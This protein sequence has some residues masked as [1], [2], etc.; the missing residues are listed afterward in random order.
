LITKAKKQH[1]LAYPPKGTL[2][3]EIVCAQT[4]EVPAPGGR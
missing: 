3:Q 4:A 1:G 2:I